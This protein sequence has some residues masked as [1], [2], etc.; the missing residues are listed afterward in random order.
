MYNC[1]YSAFVVGVVVVVVVGGVDTTTSSFDSMFVCLFVGFETDKANGKFECFICIK[2]IKLKLFKQTF[3]LNTHT[4][5]LI[6]LLCMQVCILHLAFQ[7]LPFHCTPK[8][9]LSS[10]NACS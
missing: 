2:K 8:S 1:L 9:N 10:L 3:H 7:I 5:S 6:L 4:T